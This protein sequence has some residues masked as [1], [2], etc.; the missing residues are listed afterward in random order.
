MT[1]RG[2]RPSP[3]TGFVLLTWV[4]PKTDFD[5][6]TVSRSPGKDGA[7]T[8]VIFTGSATQLKDTKLTNGVEYRY[9]VV[10]YDKAG[11]FSSG[12]DR[13]ARCRSSALL[14]APAAGSAVTKPPQL[15]WASVAGAT[16]YNVQLYRG[17]SA[18]WRRAERRSSA[19]GRSGRNSR[20]R[21]RG[22]TTAEDAAPDPRHV[23]LV[24]LARVRPEVRE[25]VRPRA[26]AEHVRRQ[27][28]TV[29]GVRRRGSGE[30]HVDNDLDQKEDPPNQATP[31][32][33]SCHGTAWR[34]GRAIGGTSA[35]R[36][37]SIGMLKSRIT[38]G[39]SHGWDGGAE[40][41]IVAPDARAVP[42]TSTG[43]ETPS[44]PERRASA[45]CFLGFA[46]AF[47]LAF[48]GI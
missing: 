10:A 19:P 27:G 41:A 32:R 48:A 39:V 9:V 26:R 40:L 42:P 12:R 23:R 2:S 7:P 25:P 24:R 33:R 29:A 1:S 34:Y 5:H 4:P 21:E 43:L 6:V 38:S 13:A 46:R 31:P 15:R 30:Q 20:S 36:M 35:T 47:A 22:S 11:N 28:I 3:A 45:G 18:K 37:S 17:R 44:V 8:T 14:Y 16:Y